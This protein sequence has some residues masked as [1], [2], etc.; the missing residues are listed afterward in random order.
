MSA[1]ISI[2]RV[3][4]TNFS[5]TQ[6]G[7]DLSDTMKKNLGF[8]T[9]YR[10][11]RLAIG[12][13][14]GEDGYP[15]LDSDS[16]GRTIKGNILFDEQ[17][18]TLWVGLLVASIKMHDP[19]THITMPILQSAVKRHWTRGVRL[20]QHDWDTVGGDYNKFIELLIARRAM[21]PHK[22]GQTH[23]V[24]GEKHHSNTPFGEAKPV[25]ITIGA[26]E[27]NGK[28]F[29]HILNGVG[30][31]PHL[32]IMGQAGSGKTRTMLDILQQVKEQTNG[33]TILLDLGKGDL[34]QNHS[35]IKNLDATLIAVPEQS[36]PLDMFYGSNVSPATAS[37]AI[38]TFRDSLSKVMQSRPGAKQ[39][40]NITD[41]L[42]TLFS[43]KQEI[44]MQD[45]K[46]SIDLYYNINGLVKDSVTSIVSDL[47]ERDIFFPQYSPQEFFS[48]SWL[49]TFAN[50][51]DISKNLAVCLLLDSLNNYMKQSTEAPCD[52]TGHR[53]ISIVLAV[54]EARSLLSLNHNA[55]SDNIR[56][57]RSKG[58][59]VMMAS[60]SPDDY[61]GRAD[62]YLEN[63]G[64]PICFRT[65]AVSNQVL[66]NMFRSKPNFSSLS[67]GQC[68]SIKDNTL[69]KIKV[70]SH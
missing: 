61:D 35:L 33:P 10:I 51:R 2:T 64:L 48:K 43:Q 60:Q 42:R 37:D 15:D 46:E 69:Q 9:N 25:E 5:P 23:N 11:A 39:L 62:D 7:S 22:V 20:L 1:D 40:H 41:A 66:Q 13:S 59:V 27:G 52:S 28:P 56:L 3:L 44:S 38:M 29:T 47:N 54:D 18:C 36:I 53:A 30:Y 4:S 16:S 6:A 17:E 19:E 45:I 50:A 49:I 57:H 26:I 55:L 34:A 70:F 68:F 31:S 63:I 58:L 65:N 32:A 8:P 21:L 67:P 14:L 24:F 12:R